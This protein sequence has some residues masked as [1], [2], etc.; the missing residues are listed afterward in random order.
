MNEEILG[1]GK[2]E[3]VPLLVAVPADVVTV[4]E[5]VAPPHTIALMVPGLVTVKETAGVPPKATEVAPVK[6]APVMITPVHVP[7]QFGVNAVM[8][9]SVTKVKMPVLLPEP[10][11]VVTVMAPVAP[12][13]TVALIDVALT[14]V[15]E[16]AAVPPKATALAPV[17]LVPLMVTTD[18]LPPLL[19]VNEVIAGTVM[20]VKVPLLVAVPPGEV[21]VMAPVAPLPTV[22]VIEVALTTVKEAA[23]VPPK[24]T[25]V[26][27][28]KLV[29]PMLTTVPAPP[30]LGV[31]E[32]MF[33]PAIKVKVPLLV[34]MPP[35]VVTVI[36]PV[37]PPATVALIEVAFTTVKEAAAV[38]PTATALAPVKLLPVMVNTVC[39]PP[40]AG[41]NEVM[42]GPG[43]KVKVPLLVAVPPG[44]VTV[45]FPVAPLPTVAAIEESLTTVKEAAAVPPMATA[46]VPVKYSPVMVTTLPGP[47][48]SG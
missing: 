29:P 22:A 25:A 31:N 36:G 34:A 42:V 35:G 6:L 8:S 21:T 15:K 11:G 39:G 46:V 47:P 2:Y 20:K 13:P 18:P 24:A 32:A 4:T 9:G 12:L 33:G 19:G 28:V 3:K 27:P 40:L 5:P 41:V 14:T 23:A 16:A 37:A 48:L 17:K 1:I 7:P 30:L 26:A 10:P 43:M 44:V 45:I 38:P